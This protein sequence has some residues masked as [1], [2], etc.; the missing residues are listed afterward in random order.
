MR[1]RSW[2]G[3]RYS[4]SIHTATRPSWP[5]TELNTFEEVVD[6]VKLLPRCSQGSVGPNSASRCEKQT[7]S[8][9]HTSCHTSFCRNVFLCAEMSVSELQLSTTYTGLRGLRMR[10]SSTCTKR[11]AKLFEAEKSGATSLRGPVTCFNTCDASRTHVTAISR[12]IEMNAS[13]EW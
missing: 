11:L 12:V 3:F 9:C 5:I 6:Y 2:G 13:H 7:T 4:A 8:K 1:N 10:C